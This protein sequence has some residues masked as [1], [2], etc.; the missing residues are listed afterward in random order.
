M[1]NGPDPGRGF[2][3]R[4]VRDTFIITVQIVLCEITI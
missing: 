3:S 4:S 1:L 2:E